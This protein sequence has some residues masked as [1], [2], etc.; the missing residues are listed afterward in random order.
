MGDFQESNIF[1]YNQDFDED[2][3]EVLFNGRRSA[4]FISSSDCLCYVTENEDMGQHTSRLRFIYN[5]PFDV[6]GDNHLSGIGNYGGANGGAGA[7]IGGGVGGGIGGG[8][9]EDGGLARR[10]KL[11][12]MFLAW[13]KKLRKKH[14]RHCRK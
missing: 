11:W 3:A 6:F 8:A 14:R 5:A 7:G 1:Q 10:A 2:L 4:P 12:R 9:G 13:S